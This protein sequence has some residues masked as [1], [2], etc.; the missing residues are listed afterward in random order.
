MRQ[1]HTTMN[2]LPSGGF[3]ARTAKIQFVTCV[4]NRLRSKELRAFAR[5][6]VYHN[7]RNLAIGRGKA[8]WAKAAGYPLG[9]GALPPTADP[10]LR[11]G[12]GLPRLKASICEIV[13][14]DSTE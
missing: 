7:W 8:L 2:L 9:A 13:T 5:E 14:L 6:Q 3:P 1:A 4:F 11:S 10:S 12:G